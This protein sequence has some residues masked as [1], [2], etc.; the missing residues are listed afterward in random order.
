MQIAH[1]RVFSHELGV[2]GGAYE[3]ATSVVEHLTTTVVEVTATD[4]TKGYGETCPLGSAY[5]PQHV[6]GARAA[7]E[8]LGPAVLGLD[9]RN[10]V[11][12]NAAMDAA[13]MGSA[14]AKAAIDI[15]CWDLTARSMG[16]RLCDLIG[17]AYTNNVPSYYGV[18]L[19]SPEETAAKVSELQAEGFRFLQLKAGGRPV[20]EDVAVADAVF[21]VVSPE[22]NVRVDPNRGWTPL[23][24]ITY[25]TQTQRHPLALEQP[26]NTFD[27]N[28]SLSGKVSHAVL[29]DE[30][31]TD[32]ATIMA[33]IDRGVAQ[34]FGMKVTRVGGI[35][36]MLA[37][38]AMCD[39]R[40]V[41]MSC[42]DTW[43]GDITNATCA[44]LGATIRPDLFIGT[45]I[46]QRYTS[47]SYAMQTPPVANPD[48]HIAIP[49]GAGLGVEPD[50]DA[51]DDP[52]L[53][54][55]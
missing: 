15:A 21:D 49:D 22:V 34:G 9:P 28:A 43:G 46:A 38:R 12:V 26:C 42:D 37:V 24:A 40:S 51:W 14:Y 52:V 18:M 39:A 30:S 11:Q 35:T 29:L 53:E 44:H 32:V 54:W 25:S 19:H 27:D 4:G 7:L 45:W 16:V 36:P 50:L 33:A 5:Q 41:H 2:A 8:L 20:V 55:S 6:G 23:Q 10:Y 1:V 13:L 31:A 17:G 48:G 47:S 3:M